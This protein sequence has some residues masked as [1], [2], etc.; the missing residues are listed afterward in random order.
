MRQPHKKRIQVAI[1]ILSEAVKK[2][3]ELNR[4]ELVELLRRAYEKAGL[5]P[6]RGTA[7]PPDIYDKELTTLYVISK[8]GLGVLN[9][10]PSL[11]TKVFYIEETLEEALNLILQNRFDEAR[12]K[13]KSISP[14][15]VI[16][17]NMIARLLRIPMT[18]LVLGFIGEDEFS[19]ILHKALET[20]PEDEKT[21]RNYARFF[22]GF[23]V[24]EAIYKGEVKSREYKEALKRA[25]ALRIGFPKATPSDA[26]IKAIAEAVF[27]MREEEL[28]KILKVT[29]KADK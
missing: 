8:Y 2:P 14:S 5:N 20:F 1:S 11:S 21:I 19:R 10:Y 24:A 25:L 13:I 15:G 16:D 4:S 12:E 23:K 3:G 6:I 17:S 22:V 27:N 7:L 26:Y 29:E 28:G 18:K 9:D